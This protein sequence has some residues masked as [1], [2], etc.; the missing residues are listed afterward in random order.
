MKKVLN[1]FIVLEI[2]LEEITVNANVLKILM[3]KELLYV[4]VKPI[5]SKKIKI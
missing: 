5:L 3:I 2:E 4:K 1:A